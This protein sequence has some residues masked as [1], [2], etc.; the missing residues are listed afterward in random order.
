[1]SSTFN[2]MDENL[3]DLY[4]YVENVCDPLFK[5]NVSS[6]KSDNGMQSKQKQPWYDDECKMFQSDFYKYLNCYRKDKSDENRE[7]L[8]V[9]THL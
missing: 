1:M 3:S 5:K 7:E 6:H 8:E 4:S 9:S 2:D